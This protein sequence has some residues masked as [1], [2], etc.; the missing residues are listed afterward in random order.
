MTMILNDC[1]VIIYSEF[2]L[3]ISFR[4]DGELLFAKEEASDWGN[5]KRGGGINA[6]LIAAFLDIDHESF[7]FL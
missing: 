5:R 4:I 1:D 6:K 2:D 7:G 3:A